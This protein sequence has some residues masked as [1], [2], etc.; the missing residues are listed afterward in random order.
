MKV[1]SR[2]LC[3]VLPLLLAAC[4][5]A[6]RIKGDAGLLNEQLA[7]EQVLA[8][9]THWTLSGRLGVTSGAMAA[10]AFQLDAGWRTLRVRT[11]WSTGKQEFSPQ[12]WSRWRVAGRTGRWPAGAA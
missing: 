9:A 3:M 10:A 11:A 7:R 12:W 1:V 4:V 5:P 6:A 8:H 2:L